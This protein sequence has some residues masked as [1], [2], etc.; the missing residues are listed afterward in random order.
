MRTAALIS[1]LCVVLCVLAV[2]E[3]K[4]RRGAPKPSS[5][6]EADTDIDESLYA[7]LQ[8]SSRV[9]AAADVSASQYFELIED[10]LMNLLVRCAWESHFQKVTSTYDGYTAYLSL[11]CLQVPVVIQIIMSIIRSL[12][13]YLVREGVQ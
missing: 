6:D 10:P 1:A 7:M 5:G 12:S 2:P 9:T 8:L 4:P 13:G 11:N 3:L